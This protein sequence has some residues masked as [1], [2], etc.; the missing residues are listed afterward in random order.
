MGNPQ[1]DDAD[2][3]G[4]EVSHAEPG[5][6]HEVGIVEGLKGADRGDGIEDGGRQHISEGA[7]NG[8]TVF[9]QAS[10]DRDDGAFANGEHRA[11]KS[12]CHDGEDGIFREDFLE[13]IARE[14][15]PEKAADEG[16]KKN[17]RKGSFHSMALHDKKTYSAVKM[18]KVK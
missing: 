7:G 5:P 17:K 8:E 11:E 13:G 18:P 12:A 3:N 10:D 4:D 16:A 6:H 14:V 15:G 2:E 9:D 1:D